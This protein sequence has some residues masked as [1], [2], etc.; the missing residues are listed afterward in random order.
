MT[1]SEPNRSGA[2]LR[3]LSATLAALLGL[4]CG[5]RREFDVDDPGSG[6]GDFVGRSSPLNVRF[7][8]GA[9][10]DVAA[11]AVTGE[12]DYRVCDAECQAYCAAQTFD[13]PVDRAMCPYLWGAGFDT[14]PVNPNEACRRLIVDTT[15]RFPTFDES[16]AECL[17][18][19]IADVAREKIL[20]DAF[21]LQNQRRW[22]DVFRYNNTAVNL[23]RIY[24]ADKI[25]GKLFGG[26]LRYDEFVQVMSAHPVVL[27]RYDDAADRAEAIF[28]IFV[29]RPPFQNER[30]DMAKLYALWE[31]G[32]HDHPALGMRLPDSMIQHRCVGEDGRIDEETA[33]ACASVLWGYHR[34]VLLPDFRSVDGQTWVGNLTKEEWEVLQTPGRI[35]GQWPQVWEHAVAQ[36]LELYLGYDLGKFVPEVLPKLV[37]YTLAHGGDIRAAHYAVLT[38][39]LYLQS[40]SCDDSTCDPA[41]EAPPWTYGPL[42]QT[43]AEQWIDSLGHVLA[44]SQ[45]A[46]DH[47]VT[48]PDEILEASVV[49]YGLV[50]A[51]R[52]KLDDELRVETRYVDLARTLGGCPDNLASGRFKTVSILNTATQEGVAR[53]LCNP[54]LE[55]DLGVKAST[56]LPADTSASAV[57]SPELAEL[58]TDHQVKRFFSREPVDAELEMARA[59][60]D[61]CV[62]KPCTAESFARALCYG[63][64]SSSE[65]LFY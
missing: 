33:G 41:S 38:S 42:R 12:P 2:R 26:F 31:N 23:E 27:R 58:I 43:E 36:V 62:P 50:E 17:G 37:E 20:E 1:H 60:A 65:M 47:R 8:G 57:L 16:A 52:W 49:G 63:L 64:L 6:P 19:P 25:V 56:L 18:R 54:S 9:S 11:R 24:D 30:E 46:C 48:S 22:A 34:V 4:A 28:N 7:E 29:G 15:G 13:N 44:R 40:T 55:P 51:S 53:T 32:Y 3:L 21:L 39:A 35:I 14:R 59:G 45:G 10:V 61:A 5:G